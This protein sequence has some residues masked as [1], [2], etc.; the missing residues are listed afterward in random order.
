LRRI[1]RIEGPPEPIAE[2]SQRPP[3]G[4]GTPSALSRSTTWWAVAPAATSA[5]TRRTIAAR[6]SSISSTP[7]IRSPVASS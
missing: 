4:P 2:T 7:L 1:P 6:A 3:R 5:A